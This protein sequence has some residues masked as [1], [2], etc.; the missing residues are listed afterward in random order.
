MVNHRNHRDD[1]RQPRLHQEPRAG[2]D[3]VLVPAGT[4]ITGG[5]NYQTTA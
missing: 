2:Q 4:R 1:D 3:R 5:A